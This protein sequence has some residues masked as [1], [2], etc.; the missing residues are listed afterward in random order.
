M[1]ARAG[2]DTNA[3]VRAAAE[4]A[5][6]DGLHPLS[7]ARLAERLGVR[8]PSL[9]N[10]V[11]GLPGLRRALA[12]YGIGA[13]HD[14]LA[15]AAIGRSG[16]EAVFALAAAY[17]NFVKAHPGLYEAMTRTPPGQDAEVAAASAAPVEVVQAVLAGYGLQ[18]DD[19]VHAVRGLR[20]LVHGF[21]TL[22]VSGGFGMPLDV[23]ESFR[24]LLRTYVAGL[25]PAPATPPPLPG[26]S[27]GRSISR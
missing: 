7:L 1:P 11:Q 16:D 12:L 25:R 22:E 5:D 21:V 10:H 2:L 4:M 20:S 27:A 18:G 24:R 6:A 13:L 23:D 9:Y 3:V 26:Q 17:R 15:S 19:A 14:A 8:V